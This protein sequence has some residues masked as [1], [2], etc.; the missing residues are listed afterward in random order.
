MAKVILKVG[1]FNVSEPRGGF[2]TKSTK[3]TKQTLFVSFVLFVVE[4]VS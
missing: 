1:Q 4:S 2:T 3:F